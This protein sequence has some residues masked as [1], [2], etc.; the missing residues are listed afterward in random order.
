MTRAL[1]LGVA[2]VV[3]LMTLALAPAA[4]RP[5]PQRSGDY[6]VKGEFL[7]NFLSFIDWPPSSRPEPEAPFRICILGADPFGAGLDARVR[8]ERID[9]HPIA[10]KRLKE[11]RL[12]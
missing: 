3:A 7:Y 6:D 2:A 10:I 1:S 11:D 9:G 4:T 8:D 12:A 5:A